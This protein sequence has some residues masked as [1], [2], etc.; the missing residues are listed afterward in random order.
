MAVMALLFVYF[1]TLALAN[2]EITELERFEL[3]NDC[4]A[5]GFDVVFVQEDH[6][7]GLKKE[8]IEI[9]ASSRLRAARIYFDR[10]YLDRNFDSLSTEDQLLGMSVASLVLTVY[11]DGPSA[12]V[13]LNYRKFFWDNVSEL[14]GWALTWT[15]SLLPTSAFVIHGRDRAKILSFVER[16]IDRFIDEYLRVNAEACGGP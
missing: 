1:G 10:N 3:F 16:E 15:N 7:I 8:Q 9:A 12:H 13:I 5:M 2:D 4:R 11:I 6:S 14:N